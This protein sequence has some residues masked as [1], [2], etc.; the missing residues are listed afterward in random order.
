MRADVSGASTYKNL[1]ASLDV[2]RVEQG[3]SW[4]HL[5]FCKDFFRDQKWRNSLCVVMGCGLEGGGEYEFVFRGE[6]DGIGGGSG[7]EIGI[8]PD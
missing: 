3:H 1:R 4:V 7:D 5:H 2:D 8:G 6:A